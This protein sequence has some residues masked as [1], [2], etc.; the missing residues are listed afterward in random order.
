MFPSCS[1]SNLLE[2]SPLVHSPLATHFPQFLTA[3][4]R[5]MTSI[6]AEVSTTLPGIALRPEVTACCSTLSRVALQMCQIVPL[7]LGEILNGAQGSRGSEGSVKSRHHADL[8]SQLSGL[9]GNLVIVMCSKVSHTGL[10]TGI[11]A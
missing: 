5:T 2:A 8:V 9:V 10:Q 11:Y 6:V 1:V 7:Q 3:M 4:N